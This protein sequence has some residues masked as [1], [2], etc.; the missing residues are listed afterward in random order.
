M[1]R[2]VPTRIGRRIFLAAFALTA[3]SCA[4]KPP[5]DRVRVSGQIEATDVQVAAP[6]GG[7]LLERRVAEDARVKAGDVVARL[8]T[9]DAELVLARARAERDQADAQL[10]L[11]QAGPRRHRRDLLP[12]RPRQ[13]DRELARLGVVGVRLRDGGQRQE[14]GRRDQLAQESVMSVPKPASPLATTRC[15]SG[16]LPQ[17][18]SAT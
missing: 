16:R 17:R 14:A 1:T 12:G 3:A 10:K 6:V 7:R 2:I 8:D 13:A 15:T 18:N 5:A 9:A 11:L 4:V